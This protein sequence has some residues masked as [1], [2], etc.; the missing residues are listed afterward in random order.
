[1]LFTQKLEKSQNVAY[2]KKNC[3]PKSIYFIYICNTDEERQSFSYF[4]CDST[5]KRMNAGMINTFKKCARN[6][7]TEKWLI[8]KTSRAFDFSLT[9]ER[10]EKK[11]NLILV[12]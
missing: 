6:M 10:A 3:Q 9:I 12:L 1:M 7:A 8:K 2:A 5:L 4:C 11:D